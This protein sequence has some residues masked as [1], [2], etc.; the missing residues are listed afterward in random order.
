MFRQMLRLEPERKP[1]MLYIALLL[2]T[3]LC[4]VRCR[5]V[6]EQRFLHCNP[7]ICTHKVADCQDRSLSVIPQAIA[8]ASNITTL[9]LSGNRIELTPET[10]DGF[11]DLK[12]LFLD[13]NLIN[14][15]PPGIFDALLELEVLQLQ[16]NYLTSLPPNIFSKLHSLKNLDVRGNSL[17]GQSACPL[18]SV[19]DSGLLA[20]AETSQAIL[21]MKRICDPQGTVACFQH[22]SETKFTCS[23]PPGKVYV[24]GLCNDSTTCSSDAASEHRETYV[25]CSSNQQGV[26][27]CRCGPGRELQ[28]PELF[29]LIILPFCLHTEVCSD[30][31]TC[32]ANEVCIEAE[33]SYHCL[34][35]TGFSGQ[36][37]TDVDECT[38]DAID[39]PCPPSINCTNS[40]GSYTCECG[41]GQI[42]SGA[43]CIEHMEA[44]V[45][46]YDGQNASAIMVDEGSAVELNCS[47]TTDQPVKY[48]WLDKHGAVIDPIPSAIH[49]E[50]GVLRILSVSYQR[51]NGRLTCRVS[52]IPYPTME[53]A[54]VVNLNL[55]A[56]L[57]FHIMA[58]F[59]FPSM[60]IPEDIFA[61]AEME[62]RHMLPEAFFA[63]ER[64]SNETHL[65]SGNDTEISIRVFVNISSAVLDRNTL[66]PGMDLSQLVKSRMWARR[67]E[68]PPMSPL[69]LLNVA[70]TMIPR[71]S[72]TGDEFSDGRYWPETRHRE[73]AYVPCSNDSTNGTAVA[74]RRCELF[75][76]SFLF[77]GN[78]DNSECVPLDTVPINA[79]FQD[80]LV[81]Y[82]PASESEKILLYVAFIGCG[83]S[84]PGIIA[85][86]IT[87]LALKKLRT[88]V[89]Q[90]MI[91]GLCISLLLVL[92]L[93]IAGIK[94][95]ASANVCTGIAMAVHYCLLSAF[96][97]T[98]ADATHLYQQVVKVMSIKKELSTLRRSLLI[99]L[100]IPFMVVVATA[101]S[102][103]ADAYGSKNGFRYCWINQRAV[104]YGTFIGPVA[105]LLLY[106][107]VV[108]TVVMRSIR[109]GRGS[110][111][112]ARNGG[113]SSS[114]AYLLRVAVSLSVLLGLTWVIGFVMLVTQNT[115]LQYIFTVLNTLQGLA[116]FIHTIRAKDVRRGWVEVVS[117]SSRLSSLTMSR[118]L[119][120]RSRKSAGSRKAVSETVEPSPTRHRLF[121]LCSGIKCVSGSD[122]SM[123]I[124][125][126]TH[127]SDISET[128][129]TNKPEKAKYSSNNSSPSSWTTLPATS[130]FS[131]RGR[132]G[133]PI[134][135]LFETHTPDANTRVQSGQNSQDM[136]LNMVA[137]E[138][139]LQ[140]AHPALQQCA[141]RQ[142]CQHCQVNNASK[143][144]LPLRT[145]SRIVMYHGGHSC[146][147]QVKICSAS[148]TTP[149]ARQQSVDNTESS[150]MTHHSCSTDPIP[151]F[152][153][154]TVY[155]CSEL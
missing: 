86:L 140:E 126:G 51:D 72:C 142:P 124:P 53:T 24:R 19:I 120:S 152:D 38:S 35:K 30:R 41:Q 101:G 22:E 66:L 147:E 28:Q 17:R 88:K 56:P 121:D 153:H 20:D 29:G 26:Q 132:R 127:L 6:V 108:L 103:K 100:G 59:G 118:Q 71:C 115:V 52:S 137:A 55:N 93:F 110:I 104:F 129:S 146:P 87:I 21:T 112:R 149:S 76:T 123:D 151:S 85:T 154:N 78:V 57:D 138:P 111:A 33:G 23:C 117:S 81:G 135:V 133:S 2:V 89:H 131:A 114:F 107:A 16:N 61:M 8:T 136:L 122:A 75:E 94:A 73:L 82:L 36:P 54:A 40:I 102:T 12:E 113:G 155:Y 25:H 92:I 84:M 69:T 96:L 37:C 70:V 91:F 15:L 134:S 5:E 34:C 60:E 67:K 80:T 90:Q 18:L 97:F 45:I 48:E 98:A 64:D 99:A 43:Q 139:V 79:Y 150:S 74:S 128:R 77:W 50:G 39:Y 31:D 11:S 49:V 14:E 116:V 148:S 65:G 32:G 144:L 1:T 95:T 141:H 68:S 27:E 7:C 62:L 47:S 105:A 42:Y 143:Q 125:G 119:S 130:Q 46:E 58:V 10:F 109:R 13:D 83:L 44:P 145:A 4:I 63:A 9:N 3:G 106:N